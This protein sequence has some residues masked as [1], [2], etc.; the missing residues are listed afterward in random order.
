M[1]K[2]DLPDGHEADSNLIDF[3]AHLRRRADQVS[4]DQISRDQ[5]SRDRADADPDAAERE[6]YRFAEYGDGTPPRFRTYGP[7]WIAMALALGWI[8]WTVIRR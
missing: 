5:V 4:Q 6:A 7:V 8:L 1:P 3:R 2:H